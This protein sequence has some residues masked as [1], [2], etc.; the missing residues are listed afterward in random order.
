MRADSAECLSN[1]QAYAAQRRNEESALAER[2]QQA[3]LARKASDQEAE[4]QRQSAEE[5]RR[6]DEERAAQRQKCSDEQTSRSETIAKLQASLADVAKHCHYQ[7]ST[8]TSGEQEIV[9]DSK[10]DLS[11]QAPSTTVV[12]PVCERGTPRSVV[13][14]AMTKRRSDAAKLKRLLNEDQ[15]CKSLASPQ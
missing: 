3:D 2:A 6:Q 11:L 4:H 12:L 8:W 1:E 5:Q 13:E 10:G 9:A 15:T 7:S 14:Y